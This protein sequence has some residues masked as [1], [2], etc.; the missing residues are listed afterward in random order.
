MKRPSSSR[1]GASAG[2]P[3]SPLPRFARAATLVATLVALLP[4]STRA[5][6]PRVHAI[7]GARIVAA[8]GQTIERGTIVVRDGIITAVGADVAVPADAR[9]WQADSLT[10]YAG[11][12]DPYV[13]VPDTEARGA[14]GRRSPPR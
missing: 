4:T 5:A 1:A 6:T 10:I 13:Q 3:A 8:P 7:V 9:I 2:T 14:S 11:L 12:I